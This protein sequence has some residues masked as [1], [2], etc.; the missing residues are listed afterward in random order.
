MEEPCLGYGL[1][2][3]SARTQYDAPMVISD[4]IRLGYAGATTM[5]RFRFIYLS[6]KMANVKF[7]ALSTTTDANGSVPI[8]L[9]P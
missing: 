1:T 4:Y 2:P 6:L 9:T 7:S 3:A 8:V 5:L